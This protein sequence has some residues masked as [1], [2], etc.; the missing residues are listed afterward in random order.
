MTIQQ[1]LLGVGASG[2]KYWWQKCD[3]T[4][5][6]LSAYSGWSNY[7]S[8][9]LVDDNENSYF[10]TH[11]QSQRTCV[12][13][14]DLDGANIVKSYGADWV[15]NGTSIASNEKFQ[16]TAKSG[17]IFDNKI[18]M[19]GM[20]L[21]SMNADGTSS[22]TSIVNVPSGQT[23]SG[24]ARHGFT[25]SGQ[26]KNHYPHFIV[27]RV[28]SGLTHSVDFDASGESLTIADSGDFNFG[29]GDFTM[30]CWVNFDQTETGALIGQSENDWSS[31][32]L[33]FYMDAG[34]V[35]IFAKNSSGGWIFAG[36]NKKIGTPPI[37]QWTHLAVTRS[38]NVF[39]F[40][41]NGVQTYTETKTDTMANV[42][43]PFGICHN[44]T[45]GGTHNCRISN[46][47]VVKGTAV[48]TANFAPSVEPLTNI[49]NT[50][51][52]CCNGSSTT[53]STISPGTITAN[54]NPTVAQDCPLSSSY[55]GGGGL[56][57]KALS[58]NTTRCPMFFKSSVELNVAN[59]GSADIIYAKREDPN[60][61]YFTSGNYE[62]AAI[63]SDGL[64]AYI[65]GTCGSN[66][67]QGGGGNTSGGSWGGTTDAYLLKI[68]YAT[69]ELITRAC[70]P[71]V[72]PSAGTSMFFGIAIDS[73]G[74]IY[75]AGKTKQG[76]SGNKGYIIKLNSSMVVQWQK[77]ISDILYIQKLVVD[78]SGNVYAVATGGGS[79]SHIMK[80]TS[81]GAMDWST[82]VTI[83]GFTDR[84]PHIRALAIGGENENL[85]TAFSYNVNPSSTSPSTTYRTQVACI[86]YPNTG[87]IT[88][89]YGDLVFTAGSLSTSD[90]TMG[91]RTGNYVDS[92]ER[93][94]L[95]YKYDNT[96][97]GNGNP[98]ITT[99]SL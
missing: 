17:F 35:K 58:P 39:R 13:G 14:F 74:N 28:G 44:Q 24:Y 71:C 45:L 79:Y 12:F 96:L 49:T 46:V 65:V 52:L 31:T 80:F 5:S 10:F 61:T 23:A 83:N 20:G 1:M 7:G 6:G 54:G 41:L 60:S 91:T 30:E 99:T 95:I 38:S 32:S 29:S 90:A 27:G 59:Y 33:L 11:S 84:Y 43:G 87:D 51:L 16:M 26:S 37:G 62:D 63:T 98:T 55:L 92:D 50:K 40:F 78:S 85:Y 70:F 15:N 3:Q 19:A 67:T 36:G 72:G 21:Q 42:S 69:G 18:Y 22:I 66:T 68:N 94:T 75:C 64:Y 48:Y 86:K 25:V 2:D 76:Y 47:R 93:Q 34:E 88:G 73:S 81:S 82:K 89:T 53:S 77:F 4:D 9:I 57:N 8:T 97:Y 56:V